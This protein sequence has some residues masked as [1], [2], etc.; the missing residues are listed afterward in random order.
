MQFLF[1]CTILQYNLVFIRSVYSFFLFFPLSIS[2]L[3]YDIMLECWNINPKDRCKFQELASM[4]LIIC[5]LHMQTREVG[6]G[7]EGD[8]GV[9]EAAKNRDTYLH[10]VE[11]PV[12]EDDNTLKELSEN[13]HFTSSSDLLAAN[14]DYLH[15]MEE[16]N[17]AVVMEMTD[18]DIS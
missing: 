9:T 5:S 13:E 15:P 1:V 10:P 7:C 4:L 12:T 17:D 6:S 8:V 18:L 14:H 16:T 11:E 2:V 3:R